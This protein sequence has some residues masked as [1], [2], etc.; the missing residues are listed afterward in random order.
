[1]GIIVRNFKTPRSGVQTSI[2]D[3][4]KAYDLGVRVAI[5]TGL[6]HMPQTPES[7]TALRFDALGGR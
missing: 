6:T 3:G 2:Y 5:P 4:E 1:M 7:C